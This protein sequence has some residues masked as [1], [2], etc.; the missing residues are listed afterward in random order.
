M[1][2]K[3]LPSLPGWVSLGRLRLRCW[4]TR[5]VELVRSSELHHDLLWDGA[6]LSREMSGQLP[7]CFTARPARRKP[8][9]L[10]ET[11]EI[12]AFNHLAQILIVGL[13]EACLDALH[14]WFATR[15][16]T[17]PRGRLEI[18][19]DA[20]FFFFFN[21][22]SIVNLYC[23]VSAVLQSESVIHMDGHISTL[24]FFFKILL[25]SLPIQA[26]TEY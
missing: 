17:V 25:D 6:G 11:Q 22:W 3:A 7:E 9:F 26:I 5:N 2:G 12:D 15:V 20:C 19:G 13:W 1:R 23:C 24:F 8:P 4:N 18:S 14:Q 16:R 21:Y 10:F